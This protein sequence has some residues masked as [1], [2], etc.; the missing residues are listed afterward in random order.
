MPLLIDNDANMG[1]LGESRYGAGRGHS[2]LAYIKID[3]GIGGGL[4]LAGTIYRGHNGSAGE[5]GHT[6]IDENG[7]PCACGNRGCLETV[8]TVP[9]IVADAMHNH[10]HTAFMSTTPTTTDTAQEQRQITDVLQAAREGDTACIAA[11]TRAGERIGAAIVNLIN[12]FNPSVIVIDGSIAR[13]GEVFFTTLQRV[14]ETASLP[15][16]RVGLQIV[17][18]TLCEKSVALGSAVAV[19]DEAFALP[20]FARG[21]TTARP[22]ETRH[23][24]ST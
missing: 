10:T 17:P 4:I 16:A 7:P 3:T 1:A 24:S 21:S 14:A 8:A 19:I 12:M 22:E 20:N 13:A 11:L 15:A 18:G 5:I 6:T 2:H 23:T 9:A